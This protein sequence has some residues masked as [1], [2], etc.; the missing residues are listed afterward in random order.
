MIQKMKNIITI[1]VPNVDLTQVSN[2]EVTFSQSIS[3]SEF[4]YSGASVT[5]SEAHKLT[6]T[7]PKADA[8][9]L[10]PGTIDGQIMY[11][12]GATPGATVPFTAQVYKL[13]KETGYGP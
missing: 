2:I 4:T 9:K 10:L 13:L 7:M 5:V 6:V 3:K 1:S 12:N 11:T 8:M